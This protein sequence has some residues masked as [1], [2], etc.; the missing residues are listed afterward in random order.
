MTTVKITSPAQ[1]NNLLSQSRVVVVDFFADWCAPCKVI[2]PVYEQLSAQ[3]SRPNRVTFTKVNVDEQTQIAQQYGISSI[4]TFMIFKNGQE[5]AKIRGAKAKDLSDAVKKLAAEAESSDGTSASGFAS[6]S[7][8]GSSWRGFDLPRSYVDVTDQIDSRGI[9]LLNSDAE[10]G[11]GSTLFSTGKPSSLES[12]KGKG[13]AKSAAVKPDW[14]ESDTD[15]QLMLF[16]PFQSMLKIHSLQLT[17]I[18]PTSSEDDSDELPMRPKTLK[19]YTNR[20]RNLGF[21]EADDIP[22]TQ[23][24]ELSPQDWDEKTATANVQLRFV[25]FQNITS[26]VIFVVDGDGDSEKTRLDRIRIIGESGEKRE[27]GKLEKPGDE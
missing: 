15:E 9:D 22:T 5:A 12:P 25:K 26:L 13:P 2:A 14:I 10:F 4:P 7:G 18:R 17:S 16:I 3:L 23:T 19:L 27:M 20:A 1:F 24:I 8:L 21:E 11:S 6:S